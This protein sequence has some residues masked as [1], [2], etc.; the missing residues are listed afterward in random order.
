MCPAIDPRPA[1]PVHVAVRVRSC[2][3]YRTNYLSRWWSRNIH[4]QGSEFH[5]G[6]GIS[7]LKSN[8]KAHFWC[9]FFV[10]C[11][12]L[13][14][15]RWILH[16]RGQIVDCS[17]MH[18]SLGPISHGH[19]HSQGQPHSFLLCT[20]PPGHSSWCIS[21]LQTFSRFVASLPPLTSSSS[22]AHLSPWF[23]H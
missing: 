13:D 5:M 19:H 8:S 10:P 22:S 15:R 16:Y 3:H 20:R 1:Q 21:L 17:Q 6:G 2:V 4:R 11:Y 7:L 23:I 14:P 9:H 12:H 18:L